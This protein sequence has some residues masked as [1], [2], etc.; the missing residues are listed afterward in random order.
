MEAA[1]AQ[2]G[3]PPA[4]LPLLPHRGG[5]TLC[6]HLI[7]CWLCLPSRGGRKF[8]LPDVLN[9][10]FPPSL[11]QSTTPTARWCSWEWPTSTP[12]ARAS[13]LCDSFALRCLTQP[14][15]FFC[16]VSQQ[17]CGRS[18]GS[19]PLWQRVLLFTFTQRF[20]GDGELMLCEQP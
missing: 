5:E 3:P 17:L 14:S 19:Q 1:N 12:S 15:R 18:S 16:G 2:V 4:H 20:W 8:S 13:S 7:T 6:V 9:R 11:L 10:R